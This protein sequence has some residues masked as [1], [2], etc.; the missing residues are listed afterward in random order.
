[1]PLRRADTGQGVEAIFKIGEFSKLT[2]VSIRMLR[3]YD[4]NGIFKPASIDNATGYR[5]YSVEQ[6]PLLHKIIFLRDIGFNVAE[7]DAAIKHWEND[8]IIRHLKNKRQEIESTIKHQQEML[9]KIGI[10]LKEIEEEDTSI[11]CNVTL[12]CIPAYKV[13]S[14]RKTIPNYFTEAELWQEMS[15]FIEHEG[16]DIPPNNLCFAIYHDL[17]HK[18]TQV[19]VEVCVVVNQTNKS[20]AGFTFRETEKIEAMACAMVYGPFENIASAYHSL[21]EWLMKHDQYKMTGKSRQIC[22]RGPWNEPDPGKYL[23]EIQIPVEKLHT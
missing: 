14:L 11:N 5:T 18:D 13:L 7:M 21:A 15:A 4:E 10:A 3:Y 9:V 8:S 23:T 1:M 12:K 16:L 22:H 20:R 17:E 6:I 19:D 2:R